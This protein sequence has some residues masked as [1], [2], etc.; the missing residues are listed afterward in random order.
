[1]RG[2]RLTRTVTLGRTEAPG[3]RLPSTKLPGSAADIEIPP[4]L[5]AL[6][7]SKDAASRPVGGILSPESPGGWPSIYAAYLETLGGQP[8]P[9]LALLPVGST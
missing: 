6:V 5:N 1:M 9:R 3:P 7:K 4:E 8:V 2:K